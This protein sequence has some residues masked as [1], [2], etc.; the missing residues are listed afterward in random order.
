MSLA[1]TASIYDELDATW[2]GEVDDGADLDPDPDRL[3]ELR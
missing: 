2:L 1:G 3:P